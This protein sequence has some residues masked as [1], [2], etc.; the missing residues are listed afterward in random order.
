MDKSTPELQKN[1][2]VSNATIQ[3][4]KVMIK[5][6]ISGNWEE[7]HGQAVQSPGGNY[8]GKKGKKS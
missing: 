3:D 8:L 2:T 4:G 6:Q 7:Y 1:G 5:N